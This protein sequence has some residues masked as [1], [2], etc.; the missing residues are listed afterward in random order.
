M[1]GEETKQ[2][3][4]WLYVGGTVLAIVTGI[5]IIKQSENEKFAPIKQQVE[6]EN[7]QMNIRVLN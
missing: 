1:N 5:A 6:E 3:R 4:F 2:D 7:A